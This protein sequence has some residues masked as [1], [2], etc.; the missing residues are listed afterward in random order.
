MDWTMD[1]GLFGYIGG[2]VLKAMQQ[3]SAFKLQIKAL[4]HPTYRVGE[5]AC[6]SR[7]YGGETHSPVP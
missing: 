4:E 5:E 6:A 1:Y 7:R 3:G 2:R